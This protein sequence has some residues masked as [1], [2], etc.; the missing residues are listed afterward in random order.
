METGHDILFFWVARMMMMGLHFMKKVPFRT[1]YLHALV[2][3]ENGEKMSKVKGNVID[4]LDVIFGASKTQLLDK[5]KDGGSPETALKN[6]EKSFPEGIPASGADALRFALAAMAAQGRNIRLSIPRIE[7]YRHFANKIWNASRFALMNLDG[8]DA[9]RFA[10]TL[11]EGTGNAGLSLADR[12][13][14]SRL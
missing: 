1:V 7:G 2:V 14:I 6:I 3:D 13:I 9:D 8:F 12:W 11:R 5:A 4:P 10:D